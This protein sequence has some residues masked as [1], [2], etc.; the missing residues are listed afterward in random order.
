MFT[1]HDFPSHSRFASVSHVNAFINSFH[2][3][4]RNHRPSFWFF[5]GTILQGWCNTT[6]YWLHFIPK[7]FLFLH[8]KSCTSPNGGRLPQ[9]LHPLLCYVINKNKVIVSVI[10]TFIWHQSVEINR[11]RTKIGKSVNFLARYVTLL[12]QACINLHFP[13]NWRDKHCGCWAS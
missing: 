5:W 8:F 1:E 13:Q 6:S 11:I 12:D 9:P 3:I 2:C 7:N 4:W 10:L